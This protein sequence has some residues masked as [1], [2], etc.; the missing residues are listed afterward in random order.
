MISNDSTSKVGKQDD[1]LIII[2]VVHVAL[3][4]FN[5]IFACSHSLPIIISDLLH[6]SCYIF[7]YFF[8]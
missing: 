2:P 7:M 8:L 3:M 6:V 4:V 1:A 5:G